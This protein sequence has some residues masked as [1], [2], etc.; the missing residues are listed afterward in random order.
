MISGSAPAVRTFRAQREVR[1]DMIRSAPVTTPAEWRKRAAEYDAKAKAALER[2]DQKE[3]LVWV[4]STWAAQDLAEEMERMAVEGLR[5]KGEGRTIHDMNIDTREFSANVKRGV[6][7]ARRKHPA[8]LKLYKAGVTISALAKEI[9]ET[10]ARVTSWMAVDEPRAI[11]RHQAE[12]LRT[13]YGI[14]LSA[15]ARISD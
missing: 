7:R 10:R 5:G 9:R 3:A 8:Q 4:R 6:G 2:G 13:K 12:Y 1:A 14:P 15:W 11:P